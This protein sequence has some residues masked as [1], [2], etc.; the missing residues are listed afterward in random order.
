MTTPQ[1]ISSQSYNWAFWFFPALALAISLWL[2]YDSYQKRGPTI[3][4]YLDDAN[5]L[6]AEKTQVRYR[7]VTIGTVQKITI[8]DDAK[9]VSVV[10]QL[11]KEAERFATA[12][13]KFWI[14][15]PKISMSGITGLETLVEGTYIAALPG[16]PSAEEQ[17]EFYSLPN[18]EIK[19]SLESTSTFYLES[20]NVE[21]VS[22]GDSI[23][24]RGLIIGNV[25]KVTLNKSAQLAVVQI[26]IQ[27]KYLRLIRTNTVFWRKVGI[28]ADL[29][30]FGSK[31]KINS[32]DSIMRGGI[33]LFTPDPPGERAHYGARFALHAT[34]PKGYEK[35]NPVLD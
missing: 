2:F 27:N 10:V 6:Q 15:S 25:T 24:F 18:S 11:L 12:G 30:L 13:S 33:D 31:V 34:A 14:V 22:S 1:K 17:T 8:A 29:G 4:I 7:G 26:N 20:P 23:T 3:S 28:Q 16:K 32:L 5:G 19:D 35:W 21:S 9:N